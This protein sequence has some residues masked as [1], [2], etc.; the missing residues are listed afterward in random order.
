MFSE[1]LHNI[2]SS[3]KAEICIWLRIQSSCHFMSFNFVSS[4]V[5][6]NPWTVIAKEIAN[7]LDTSF[8]FLYFCMFRKQVS[9][10][11]RQTFQLFLAELCVHQD[12]ADPS[13]SMGCQ[14]SPQAP[15][16]LWLPSIKPFKQICTFG[17]RLARH[18]P[19]ST[20]SPIITL[21]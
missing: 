12:G 9:W 2:S 1:P 11:M 8:L 6:Q 18:V 15:I 7:L 21:L 16:C 14:F 3:L 20:P 19:W 13:V 17:G 4:Q 10:G 5:L